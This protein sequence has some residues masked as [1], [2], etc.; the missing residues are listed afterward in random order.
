MRPRFGPVAIALTAWDIWRR[1]P[2]QQRRQVM[3]MARRHGPRVASKVLHASARAKTR[4]TAKK[5]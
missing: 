4:R 2:P 3:N 5:P 1:L